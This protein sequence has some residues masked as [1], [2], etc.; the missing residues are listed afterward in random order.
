MSILLV[1][2]ARFI[3]C[4]RVALLFNNGI[5]SSVT[6]IIGGSL[7]LIGSCCSIGSFETTL[8]YLPRLA[9]VILPVICY[10]KFW[11]WSDILC[12]LSR[13]FCAILFK[14]VCGGCSGGNNHVDEIPVCGSCDTCGSVN[15]FLSLLPPNLSPVLDDNNG[16][17]S[18]VWFVFLFL[19]LLVT[20]RPAARPA[21]GVGAAN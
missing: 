5:I 17:N 6:L 7:A 11:T 18:S 14:I 9:F 3:L 8:E 12:D 1:L 21:G 15:L 20:A 10:L 16:C 19:I 13:I 4:I 2:L